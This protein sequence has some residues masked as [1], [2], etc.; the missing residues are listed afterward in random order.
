MEVNGL[1]KHY[2]C[3]DFSDKKDALLTALLIRAN[4]E[5]FLRLLLDNKISDVHGPS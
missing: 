3:I 2:Y 5:E 4:S 1:G